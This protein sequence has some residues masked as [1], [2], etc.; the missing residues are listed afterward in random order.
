MAH[1]TLLTHW[2]RLRTYVAEDRDFRMWQEG[3]RRRINLWSD[4]DHPGRRLRSSDKTS[5]IGGE[6]KRVD[7]GAGDECGQVTEGGRV[8]GGLDC[9]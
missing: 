9:R 3:L 2:D 6:G 4:D 1:E 8:T 5:A 7:A